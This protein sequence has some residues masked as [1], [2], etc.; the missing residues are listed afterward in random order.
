MRLLKSTSLPGLPN[1]AGMAEENL[2]LSCLIT[3]TNLADMVI[4]VLTPRN[5][6]LNLRETTTTTT[7]AHCW[8]WTLPC[9]PDDDD[10][11][12]NMSELGRIK[13]HDAMGYRLGNREIR[14]H[15]SCWC[16][17]FRSDGF[18]TWSG[19][20]L[21]GCCTLKPAAWIALEL[22]GNFSPL[23]G[24]LG[25]FGTNDLLDNS[26]SVYEDYDVYP[27]PHKYNHSMSTYRYVRPIYPGIHP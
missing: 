8:A 21:M 18:I 7:T 11:D 2:R 4:L 13:P 17:A 10:D 9:L 3:T 26:V 15:N 24:N 14:A 1:N 12:E 27:Y 19:Q 22:Y 5:I 23:S 25:T 20:E 6:R 16:S